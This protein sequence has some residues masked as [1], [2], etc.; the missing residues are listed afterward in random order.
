MDRFNIS[1][2]L[3]RIVRNKYFIATLVFIFW[4]SLFD[5][6]NLIERY[7]LIQELHQIEKDR[8][9]YTQRIEEDAARLK[10]L[11]TNNENLEKFARE[12]YLMRKDNEDV[13]FIVKEK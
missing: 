1:P 12:Q 9:Y 4:V 7:S 5:E 10:E 6:N 8:R 11:R 13:F 3:L 2:G